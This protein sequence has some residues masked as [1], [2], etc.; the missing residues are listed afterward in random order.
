[1]KK[2]F[3]FL[4]IY[5]VSYSQDLNY[6]YTVTFGNH[7]IAIEEINYDFSEGDII[8]CFFINS[9]G[10]LQCCGST[11]YNGEETAFVSA[12]PDDSFTDYNEGFID[13][14]QMI[15]AFHLCDGIDYIEQSV[16]IFDPVIYETNGISAISVMLSSPPDCS[17]LYLKN[18]FHNSKSMLQIIDIKGGGQGGI[19]KNQLS[20]ILYDDGTVEK[21]IITR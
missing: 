12:W 14:D 19:K 16:L 21:K 13:G 2:L 5:I 4:L 1:M 6:E 18:Y 8:G 7:V 20:I 9:D 15:L 11:V 10:D 17:N 3:F